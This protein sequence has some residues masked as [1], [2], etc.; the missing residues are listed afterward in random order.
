MAE[1]K[2]KSPLAW[3]DLKEKAP[4]HHRWC[5]AFFNEENMCELIDNNIAEAFNGSLLA[6]RKMSVVSL[7][8]QI[9]RML[10]ERISQNLKECSKWKGGI[11]PRIW[12]VI[13]KNSRAAN[14]CEVIFNGAA[15]YEIMHGEDRYIVNLSEKTC[16][17]KKYTLS[18]IP[19][20]HAITA[21]RDKRGKVE[22]YVSSWLHFSTYMRVYSN[23]LQP[24][25]GRND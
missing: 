4:E 22:E 7:F 3:N 21:I 25:T 13:E 9:R 11:G 14:Y 5:R 19:C 23:V 15:G 1:L 17:C 12:R 20:T 2:Q 24:M 10:M 8:E 6:A 18:G 16:S